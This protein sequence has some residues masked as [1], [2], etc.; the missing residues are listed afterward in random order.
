LSTQTLRPGYRPA[1][2]TKRPQT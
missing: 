1:P 2:V